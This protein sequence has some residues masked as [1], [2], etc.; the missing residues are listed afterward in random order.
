M[1]CNCGKP[2]NLNELQNLSDPKTLLAI[3]I[4]LSPVFALMFL[5]SWIARRS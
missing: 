5:N 4:A 3:S 2:M 1:S